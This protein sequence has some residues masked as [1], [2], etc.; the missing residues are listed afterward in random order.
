MGKGSSRG[1]NNM[2]DGFIQFRCPRKEAVSPIPASGNR[3]QTINN[4]T[5]DACATASICSA[6]AFTVPG[7][8]IELYCVCSGAEVIN[9]VL[10]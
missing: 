1:A 8:S 4:V 10:A 5:D 2:N 9:P 7:R 6:N 3:N